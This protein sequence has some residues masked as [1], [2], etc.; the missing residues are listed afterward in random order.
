MPDLSSYIDF[1]VRFDLTTGIPKMILTD[2][3]EYPS[4]VEEDITG[5]F[6]ITSPDMGTDSGSWSSPDVEWDGDEL[7]TKELVLRLNDSGNIQ[8]G[9]YTVVYNVDHPS[10]TP[11]VLSRTFN[12]AYVPPTLN[13]VEDFDVFTPELKY[14][15]QTS[16]GVSGYSHTITSREWEAA[17]TPTGT[18]TG[19]ASIFDLVY[20][21]EYYDAEYDMIFSVNVLYEHDTY[22]YLSIEDYISK[23]WMAS[24]DT[25][26]P[27]EELVDY[28]N[29]L[30]GELDSSINNESLYSEYKAR[31]EYA[32]SLLFNIKESCNAGLLDP[33]NTYVTEFLSIT[34]NFVA[35]P[36][37]NTNE[38]ISEYS[39][40]PAPSSLPYSIYTALVTQNGGEDLQPITS[41]DLTIGVTYY[42]TNPSDGDWTNVGAPNNNEATYFVATGTT[43]NSWGASGSLQFDNGAPVVIVLENTIGSIA[44]IRDG[45]G[46][47]FAILSNAFDVE[48][49]FPLLKHSQMTSTAIAYV[50]NE[51]SIG[52]RTSLLTAQTEFQNIVATDS[53]SQLYLAPIEIRVYN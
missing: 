25:P 47:Y 42:I 2:T 24:A 40:A 50:N 17:S 20:D 9:N 51:N 7:T 15:D 3:S 45:I 10:Y 14:Y 52:V 22:P 8:A 18:L 23:T 43:P 19:S 21:S 38:P 29:D 36:Y 12:T 46:N 4:G 49:T 11:T 48:K 28:L 27:I 16:Y 13:L 41:G 39:C 34:N 33:L 32:A 30:K 31:Y 26:P 37:T 44:W 5:Y 6:S 1:S 53:D 35:P